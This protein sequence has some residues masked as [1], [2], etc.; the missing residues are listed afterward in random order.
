[1]ILERTLAAVFGANCYVLAEGP[2][3]P[4]VVVDPGAGAS[5]GAL[6]LLRSNRLTLGAVLLTHGHADHV[7]DAQRLID[8]AHTE[9]LLS[10]HDAV[11]APVYVPEPDRYRLDDP[12][13][14]TGIRAGGMGFA[15]MAGSSWLAPTDLRVFPAE[16]FTRAFEVVPG[17][18]LQAVAAP[19]HSEGS[20]MFFLNARLGD[21]QLLF[22]AEVLDDPS[23]VE[24]RDYLVALS[25][26]VIF[27]GSVGRTD[28]PGGDQVQ[29]W[30]T[31][32]FLAS[33]VSPDTVLLP[34]HGAVTT[35]EHEHHGNPYL[36]EAKVRGGDRRA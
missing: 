23:T 25:G 22:E 14:T 6:A 10:S 8:T 27:K 1:M 32:R 9:G 11:T 26:D 2:G 16:G 30:A 3:R 33:A 24:E 21:N 34:G 18:G 7:W 15:E 4:A 35:M 13:A 28:L 12:D 5:R 31:L 36:A 19:G 29:M 17:V 20:S